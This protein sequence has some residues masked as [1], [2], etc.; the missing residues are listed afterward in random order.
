[1]TEAQI[2]L[3]R[4]NMHLTL[5][6]KIPNYLTHEAKLA[7]NRLENFDFEAHKDK[8]SISE[9]LPFLGPYRMPDQSVYLGQWKNG[10]RHGRGLEIWPDGGQYE[11]F[12]AKDK[13]NGFGR[14][15]YK[16]GDVFLIQWKDNLPVGKIGTFLY[17]DG[18]Q[19][20]GQ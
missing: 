1:M 6:K 10:H 5:E 8:E 18:S 16:S 3:H 7:L 2:L 4:P 12:F 11:G 15:V 9:A 13:A 17:R 19:Y 20:Q 14:M